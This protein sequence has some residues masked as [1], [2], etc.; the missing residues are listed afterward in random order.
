MDSIKILGFEITELNINLKKPFI[1]ALR[2]V[3]SITDILVKIHTSTD[4]VGYGEAC[5]VSAI[6][7]TTNAKVY[8]DL[9]EVIFPALLHE[10]INIHTI[11][12][13]LHSLNTSPEARACVDIALYDI[14]AKISSLS[15]H[16]YLGAQ[17]SFLQTDI[18]ISVNEAS[19]MQ[20][21]SLEA[22]N[23]GFKILKIKLDGDLD[24]NVSRLVSINAVIDDAISLRLDPNQALDLDTCLSMLSSI[25]LDKIECIEQPF[26]AEDFISMKALKD[27]N[28]IPVLADESLF[29]L[30]DAQ[31]LLKDE[32]IDLLNIKLMK[33]AGIFEAIKIA[34]LAKSYGK[35]CMIG[36]M[37]EGPICLLAAVHFALSQDNIIMADL[38]SPLYLKDHPLLEPF[39]LKI[40]RIHLDEKEGLGVDSIIQDLQIFPNS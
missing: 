13:R 35:D 10:E 32:A 31:L 38:D 33:S 30:E 25:P 16:K 6:T 5:A 20:K 4:I 15:L 9:H 14:L 39:H 34:K 28:I 21:D 12:T 29:S 23:S 2:R 40:D 26:K 17:N 27:K 3:D 24:K 36:S 19:L 37:L 18:T 8:K 22:V 7:G 1:T 11:F